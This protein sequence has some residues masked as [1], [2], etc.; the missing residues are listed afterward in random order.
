VVRPLAEGQVL[1]LVGDATGRGLE[2]ALQSL[3][4][5][6][7]VEALRCGD[8]R[9]VTPSQLLATLNQVALGVQPRALASACAAVFDRAAQTITCAGAGL[10]FPQLRRAGQPAQAIV[11]RGNRLGDLADSR[12]AER[13]Q[14][15]QPGDLLCWASDGLIERENEH[16]EEFGE[17]RLRAA[18]DAG[19]DGAAALRDHVLEQVEAFAR[20][21]PRKDDVLFVVAQLS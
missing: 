3:V 16:A 20:G 13:V 11:V 5:R 8:P 6:V 2:A 21:R 9:A 18:I 17:R 15:Y 10:P 19:P 7:V 1:L 4:T 14:P 12:Y